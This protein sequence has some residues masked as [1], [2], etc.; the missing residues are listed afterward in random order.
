L[1]VLEKKEKGG[2]RLPQVRGFW[3]IDDFWCNLSGGEF[4]LKSGELEE[5]SGPHELNGR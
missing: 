3:R 2:G 4:D 5:L 1:L